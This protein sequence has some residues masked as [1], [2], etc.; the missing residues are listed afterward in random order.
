MLLPVSDPASWRSLRFPIE[1]GLKL[2]PFIGITFIA[3]SM[4]FTAWATRG[5]QDELEGTPESDRGQQD[6]DQCRAFPKF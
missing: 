5:A 1:S 6:F 2:K 3:A 4:L